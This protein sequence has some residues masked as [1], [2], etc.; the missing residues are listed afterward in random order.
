MTRKIANRKKTPANPAATPC[1]TTLQR[2]RTR[3]L[4]RSL[5]IHGSVEQLSSCR[6]CRESPVNG[7]VLSKK[8]PK[9][10]LAFIVA[11]NHNKDTILHQIL[12]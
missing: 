2:Y 5:F 9:I 11:A 6:L 1:T 12:R 4:D 8:S 3:N 7:N 10:G